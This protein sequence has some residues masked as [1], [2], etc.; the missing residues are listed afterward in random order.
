MALILK[1]PRRQILGDDVYEQLKALI[2]DSSIEPGARLNIEDLA[3]RLEVSPTPVRESLA[4]LE[5]EG[6]TV[7][8]PLKGYRT[9]DLLEPH[10]LVE[11]YDLRLLLEGP[12]ARRA[13][14]RITEEQA[15]ALSAEMHTVGEIPEE[16]RYEDYL[17]LTA[18]DVR[19]HELILTGA[20]NET[21]RQAFIRTHCHLH[22]F[23]LTYGRPSGVHTISEHSAVVEAIIAGDGAAA[24][25]AMRT[26]LIQSRDRVLA[27]IS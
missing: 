12:S 8:L 16:H 21:V 26:H 6:L 10:G 5:S 15:E 17:P 19:L 14:E 7:K 22:I 4:R 25:D 18:H 11:L 24:E 23:R 20:G 2:M 3:R 27:G 1:T 9:T 13:A